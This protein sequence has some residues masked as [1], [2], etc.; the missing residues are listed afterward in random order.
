MSEQAKTVRIG[1]AGLGTVGGGVFQ[2]LIQNKEL[3]H[4]RLG[5]TLDVTAIAVRNPDRDRGF[6]VDRQLFVNDWKDLVAD[7]EIDIIIEL[8]GGTTEAKDLV[9]AALRSGKSVVTGNKALL[10]EHGAE[11]FKVVEE[12]GQAIHYEAAVA[13]GIP[14][15][16]TLLES[17][18]GNHIVS[19][20]GIINGTCNYI[21]TRMATAD[22][23]YGEALKEAMDKGYA[24]ADPTLDINGMDAAHKAVIIASLAYG[25]W[26]PSDSMHVEGIEAV[27]LID[28]QFASKLGY[29]IKLL[30]VIKGHDDG[31][32]EVRTQ[33]SL[34][35]LDHILASVHGVF[36]AIAVHGDIVGET[37]FYGS[38]AGQNPTS[39]SVISDLADAAMAIAGS[40]PRSSFVPHG[41]YGKPVAIEDTTSR[42]YLRLEAEARPGV[43]AQIAG[44]LADHQI[45]IISVLQPDEGQGQD[46]QTAQL[47]L[48]LH[49]ARYGDAVAARDAIAQLSC[50]LDKPA[51]FRIETLD[52]Q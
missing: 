11:I 36:N 14:I 44:L 28:M 35:P 43:L 25:S 23:S 1:L 24:E 31:S 15:I 39:S 49:E 6:P 33:P 22:L 4:G 30:S 29:S 2:N 20:Y 45:G 18:V 47:I 9:L 52:P 17:L 8:I 19:A 21:L 26:L 51:L 42:Y 48:T 34:I 16:K 12:T 46:P 40:K 7:P 32:I 38:G 3:L 50:I 41:I 27:E 37:L 5:I 10:A 13:G